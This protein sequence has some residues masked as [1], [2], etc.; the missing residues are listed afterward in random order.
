M[1]V[2]FLL[3]FVL[4]RVFTWSRHYSLDKISLNSMSMRASSTIGEDNLGYGA[5]ENSPLDAEKKQPVVVTKNEIGA[6]ASQHSLNKFMSNRNTS[7]VCIDQANVFVNYSVLLS[8]VHRT[9][10]LNL[11]SVENLRNGSGADGQCLDNLN[12]YVRIELVY[13]GEGLWKFVICN[14]NDTC[15]EGCGSVF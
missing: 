13:V 15:R 5:L 10:R 2:L 8:E 11:I 6:S 7:R 14:V 1:T 4:W 3:L 12:V 9:L